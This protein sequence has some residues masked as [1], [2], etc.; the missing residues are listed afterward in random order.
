MI[1]QDEDDD[2]DWPEHQC[3]CQDA[4]KDDLAS[5]KLS[6]VCSYACR[7][8]RCENGK[9]TEVTHYDV[10][11]RSFEEEVV[12]DVLDDLSGTAQSL[13]A[14]LHEIVYYHQDQ[15]ED[16]DEQENSKVS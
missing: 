7:E 1:A 11:D 8:E 3:Y 15:C 10:S 4:V 6:R 2:L 13:R 16:S 12:F 9:Q 14:Q 5:S